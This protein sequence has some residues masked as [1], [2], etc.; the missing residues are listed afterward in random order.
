MSVTSQPRQRQRRPYYG[1]AAAILSCSV[2]LLTGCGSDS[3]TGAA[4]PP[5]SSASPAESYPRT[6]PAAN[7]PVTLATRPTRI[8]SLSAT[9]T[10]ML[11]AVGAGPQ[12]KAV[13]DQSNYPAT[14]PRTKL[15]GFQPNLEAIAK[16]NPDLVVVSNDI[17]GL[18]AG[19]GK[20]KIPVLLSPAATKIEDS[21]TQIN[22][23]G[24]LT[25]HD[26]EASRVATTMQRD[27]AAAVSKTPKR[28]GTTVY[29]ELG[30]DLYS[31]NSRTFI[32]S[33]YSRLGLVNI[34]DK[35]P[36]SA[37]DYPKLAAEFVLTA[38]PDLVLLADT[39]CCKQSAATVAARPGWS[40]LTAVRTGNVVPLDDDV[41]S[42]WGPRI[43]GLVQ[44]VAA[45]LAR[46]PAPAGTG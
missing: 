10:E 11:F 14:A 7:G 17:K 32:G 21:Y 18:V 13:D 4:P 23:I 20:L 2:L 22:Q 30:P 33:L 3:S 42:R 44:A 28:P 38:N 29:H 35:A 25:G 40:K 39:K 1:R 19:L 34:A 26:G 41:A 8:V 36:K 24:T 27:L 5:S 15:S 9:A 37:G 12:V 6:V 16:Y 31:A 45:R 46:L 43:V